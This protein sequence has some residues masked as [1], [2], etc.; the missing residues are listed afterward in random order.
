MELVARTT[1]HELKVLRTIQSSLPEAGKYSIGNKV[2]SRA[3]R[4]LLSQFEIFTDN[5]SDSFNSL[6][7]IMA[8]AKEE[9]K[10]LK[11]DEEK[12]TVWKELYNVVSKYLLAEGEPLPI[13]SNIN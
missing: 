8:F 10:L 9:M 11:D 12:Y 3:D 13:S 2:F 7:S 6:A 4:K 1:H 5:N